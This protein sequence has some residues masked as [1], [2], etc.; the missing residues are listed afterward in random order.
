MD[1]LD[2][3]LVEAERDASPE[4]FPQVRP[5]NSRQSTSL[6][7]SLNSVPTVTPGQEYSQSRNRT[8]TRESS[9][10]PIELCRIRT[11]R[12]QQ[13]STVG[14]LGRKQ[15]RPFEPTLE[16]GAGKPLPPAFLDGEDYVVEFLGPN[17]PLHPQNWPFRKK[18][19]PNY[20][21]AWRDSNPD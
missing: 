10:H 5:Y 14:S 8:R 20:V 2:R 19:V 1:I 21:R 12:L 11:Q 7:H 17:D 3:D 9:L 13:R 15:S 4:R 18:C 6:G 16:I